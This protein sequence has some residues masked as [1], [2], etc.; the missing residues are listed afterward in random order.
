MAYGELLTDYLNRLVGSIGNCGVCQHHPDVHY[1]KL[2]VKGPTPA[3]IWRGCSVCECRMF[4][5]TTRQT[6][7]PASATPL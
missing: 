7:Q 5:P 4:H 1:A 2:A 6:T 3:I